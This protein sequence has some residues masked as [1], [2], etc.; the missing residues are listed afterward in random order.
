MSFNRI[1][2]SLIAALMILLGL[3]LGGTSQAEEK[4]SSAWQPRTVENNVFG[5]GEV[6]KFNMS[7][8]IIPAGTA[9]IEI[10]PELVQYR[11]AS[12]FD[13]HTW[14]Y[15]AKS[16]DLFFKV[17]DEIHS[18]MDTAGLFTW[19]FK[20]TLKEGGYHDVKIVDY[21]QPAGFAYTEDDGVPTDTSAIPHYVQ[22]AISA[23]FYFRLQPVEVGKSIFIQIHDIKKTYPMRIDIL[24][25]ETI[26]VPA[27][28]FDCIKTEPVLE[29]AGIFK[30]KGRIF[31][32]F[33]NDQYRVPVL[34]KTKVMIGTI[35]ARLKEWKKG[36][37]EVLK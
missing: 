22:D 19:Y 30:S 25:Y 10:L 23:L 28:T 16:F 14:A 26:D 20:K 6:F 8:G 15:S 33:T 7:Y 18:Y 1:P 12:C 37:V 27:G 13:I 9:G 2:I 36:E 34:M 29:S 21:N 17:R 5:K 4:D 11:G 24:G 3:A 32:W 31:I 35:V